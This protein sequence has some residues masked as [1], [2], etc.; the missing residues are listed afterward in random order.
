M[1]YPLLN[2]LLQYGGPV[3]IG[4]IVGL[5]FKAYF[6]TRFQHK[7]RDYQG[8]II[9][10]HEIILELEEKNGKLENKVKEFENSFTKESYILN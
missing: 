6:A 5:L 10:S 7:M 1:I 2:I 4:I 3:A 9:R 8:E